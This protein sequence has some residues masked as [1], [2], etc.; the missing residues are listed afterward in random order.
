MPKRCECGQEDW[1]FIG[2]ETNPAMDILCCECAPQYKIADLI[3]AYREK[4][5]RDVGE[6][7]QV[8][9]NALRREL[10]G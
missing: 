8:S 1:A 9:M 10:G 3:D 4:L 2:T 5:A 6:K 7:V